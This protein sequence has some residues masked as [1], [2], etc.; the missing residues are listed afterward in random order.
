LWCA[1]SDALKVVSSGN[2]AS[3]E[4]LQVLCCG[5]VVGFYM[6]ISSQWPDLVLFVHS[7]GL[8]FVNPKVYS[9]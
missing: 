6:Y 4:L 5:I 7:A 3:Q 9:N 8:G 1:A 2:L